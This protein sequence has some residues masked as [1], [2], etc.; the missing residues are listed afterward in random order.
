M[1][2]IGRPGVPCHADCSAFVTLCYNWSG[3]A[4]PNGQGYDGHRLHP[5]RFLLMAKKSR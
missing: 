2:G 3:A 4:D 5:A 1:E